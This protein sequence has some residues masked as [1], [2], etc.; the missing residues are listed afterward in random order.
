[1]LHKIFLQVFTDKQY[2]DQEYTLYM[3]L[4]INSQLLLSSGS[5]QDP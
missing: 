2:K 1:M 3:Y 4:K 5:V